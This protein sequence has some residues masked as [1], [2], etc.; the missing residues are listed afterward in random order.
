MSLWVC[1]RSDCTTWPATSGSGV[2]TGTMSASMGG[3]RPVKRT[4]STERRP[5]C[6]ASGAAVGLD[7]RNCVEART[8]EVVPLWLGEDA[9]AFAALVR[10]KPRRLVDHTGNMISLYKD[11]C[12]TFRFAEDRIIPRPHLEGVEAGGR[13]PSSRST[14]R[15]VGLRRITDR[16]CRR[17]SMCGVVGAST[18][19]W[20]R[21]NRP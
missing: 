9:W 17:V 16:S 5:G 8:G 14:P 7:L 10:W 6:G 11:P 1:R 20:A 2:G 13:C 19:F 15:Q 4:R 3:L 21:S 12:F 18:R